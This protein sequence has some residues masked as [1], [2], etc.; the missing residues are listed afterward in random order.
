MTSKEEEN[1]ADNDSNPKPE[2]SRTMRKS[3]F[4]KVNFFKSQEKDSSDN[5][6]EEE[7]LARPE[8]WS[9][10]VLNDPHTHEV[11]GKEEIPFQIHPIS[12]A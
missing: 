5:V 1:G 3:F 11:P 7:D 2:Q 10:G 6:D 12:Q 8:R 4:S 9:M